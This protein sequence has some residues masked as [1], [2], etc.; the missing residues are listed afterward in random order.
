MFKNNNSK[1]KEY[2]KI[3]DVYVDENIYRNFISYLIKNKMDEGD[4]LSKILEKGIKNYW[5]EYYKDLKSRLEHIKPLYEE[6]KRDN[7][8]LKS[9]ER[10]NNFLKEHVEKNGV[11]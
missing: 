5:L 1:N 2:E 6:C 3:V 4:A 8:V 11:N 7:E 10:Q 9:L